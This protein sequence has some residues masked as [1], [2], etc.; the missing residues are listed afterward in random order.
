[1]CGHLREKSASS[2][3][4]RKKSLFVWWDACSSERR[5][6]NGHNGIDPRQGGDGDEGDE[7]ETWVCASS[8]SSTIVQLARW[9]GFAGAPNA[10]GS[11]VPRSDTF[12][13]SRPNT[14]IAYSPHCPH[15]S[16]ER[17]PKAHLQEEDFVSISDSSSFS[18]LSRARPG[19]KDAEKKTKEENNLK[20]CFIDGRTT[21]VKNC[22]SF[23]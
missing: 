14:H 13:E 6:R 1:M 11:D 19:K 8:P 4:A 23:A 20:I 15:A 21:P 7:E 17:D 18:P 5:R 2:H 10:V 22:G 9:P 12:G 3:T 16:R